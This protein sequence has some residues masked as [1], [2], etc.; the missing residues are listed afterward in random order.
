M[1]TEGKGIKI[2]DFGIACV[3]QETMTRFTGRNP[4]TSG[5]LPYMAPEQ[6]RGKKQDQRTDIYAFGIL[7]YEM[8]SG[9]PPF[10]TGMIEYQVLHEEPDKIEGISENLWS[11]IRKCLEKEPEKRFGKASEVREALA[12]KIAKASAAPAASA[13][14]VIKKDET[15][16]KK[17]VSRQ[18]ISGKK[19]KRYLIT[20]GIVSGIAGLCILAYLFF[21]GPGILKIETVPEA[22]EAGDSGMINIPAGEFMMGCSPSDSECGEDEKPYHKVYLDGYYIDKYEVTAGEFKECV[23]AGKCSAKNYSTGGYCTYGIFDKKAHPMNC[24]NWHGAKE[25]CEWAGKR[26]PTE[27]EWEKAARG[28]TDTKYPWGDGFRTGMANCGEGYCKDGYQTT[29]PV[30]SFK[31]NGY[32]LFDMIGNVW[33][34]VSDWY[35]EKYY[36]SSAGKNPVG[37]SSGSYKVLRGGS[38]FDYLSGLMRVSARVRFDPD[39]RND[40]LG[41]RCA[42]D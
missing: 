41:F 12:G 18:R 38:W 11:V 39:Y 10:H 33:E 34:W 21:R 26:L 6:I 7:M 5:T 36:Q 13:P 30:G 8:L 20:A 22:P 32:G 16:G 14:E 15:A 24:V 25:Y 2:L 29:S 35:D 28:G 31:A 27:A 42:K 9:K 4:L 17:D 3:L 40:D 1:V 23:N 37:P 19:R